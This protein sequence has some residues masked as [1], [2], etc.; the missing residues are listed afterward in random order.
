MRATP[1][2]TPDTPAEIERRLATGWRMV[3]PRQFLE[4]YQA[5]GYRLHRPMR[6]LNMARKRVVERGGRCY[7]CI[8]ARLLEMD[9]GVYAHN[10]C[11]RRDASYH[12]MMQLRGEM[13]S[14][15]RG[16]ILEAE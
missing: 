12:A 9:T 1:A 5:L 11:S 10:R 6:T 15:L 14:L 4:A 3:T 8:P 2:L 16:A 7:E 13:F